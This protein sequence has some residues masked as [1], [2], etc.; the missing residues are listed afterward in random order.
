MNPLQQMQIHKQAHAELHEERQRT[1][2]LTRQLAKSAA[3]NKRGVGRRK[4]HKKKGSKKKKTSQQRM[5][6]DADD[7]VMSVNPLNNSA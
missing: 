7:P 1:I 6:E 2:D 5:L 4:K 3:A